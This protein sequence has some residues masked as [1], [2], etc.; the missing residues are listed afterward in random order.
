MWIVSNVYEWS[1]YVSAL[2]CMIGFSRGTFVPPPHKTFGPLLSPCFCF[3]QIGLF[4]HP[5]YPHFH[6][7]HPLSVPLSVILFPLSPYLLS[8][9]LSFIALPS[10]CL[11]YLARVPVYCTALTSKMSSFHTCILPSDP[12]LPLSIY[13]SLSLVSALPRSLLPCLPPEI[14]TTSLVK[15]SLYLNSWISK[16]WGC[17]QSLFNNSQV[18]QWSRK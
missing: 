17:W 5:L 1:P 4:H 12:S 3:M 6:S 15:I 16:P 7:P 8:K 9:P 11:S 13:H 14:I 18:K 10:F 2:H